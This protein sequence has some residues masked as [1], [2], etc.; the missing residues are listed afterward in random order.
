M[1]TT[2][3]KNFALVAAIGLFSQF[4]SAQNNANGVALKQIADIVSQLNHYP[5]DADLAILDEI[6]ANTEL[7]QGVREMA[8]AVASIEHSVN[9]EGQGAMDAI[10]TNA[11]APDRAK[12]LAGIIANFSHGASDDAKAQLARLFP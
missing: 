9:E 12:V 1:K 6:I 2:I 3:L 4:A 11:Q 5:A 10:Q 8:N 7:A